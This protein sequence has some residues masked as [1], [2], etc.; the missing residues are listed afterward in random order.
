HSS[1]FPEIRWPCSPRSISSCCPRFGRWRAFRIP[2]A[3]ESLRE[4]RRCFGTSRR[5]SIF[6]AGSRHARRTACSSSAP[7]DR[8]APAFSARSARAEDS[9]A[10]ERERRTFLARVGLSAILIQGSRIVGNGT[11]ERFDQAG[12]SVIDLKIARILEK[13]NYGIELALQAMIPVEREKN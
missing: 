3:F 6:S 12:I 1:V 9:D 13:K 2:R 11:R 10:R 7:R 4:R 8:K 5:A